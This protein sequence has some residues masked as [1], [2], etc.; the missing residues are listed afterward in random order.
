MSDLVS[1]QRE[2]DVVVMT[3][4]DGK[5]NSFNSALIDAVNAAFDRADKEAGD[6]S[7]LMLGNAKVHSSLFRRCCLF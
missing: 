6:I 5:M 2:G 3:L 1:Y 4:D 7:I